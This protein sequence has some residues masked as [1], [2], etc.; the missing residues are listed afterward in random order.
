MDWNTLKNG[1][2]IEADVTPHV[3]VWIETSQEPY[4]RKDMS[5]TSCR[6][7]DWNDLNLQTID[8]IHVTPH[9]GVWIETY[10]VTSV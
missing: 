9:V 3:G 5:H 10:F 8:D 1:Q 4:R 2:D 6:C 7:V